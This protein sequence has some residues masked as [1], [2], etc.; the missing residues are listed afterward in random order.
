MTPD[1][2]DLASPP[3]ELLNLATRI[4]RD[5]DRRLRLAAL[6]RRISLSQL[7]DEVLDRALP[8]VEELAECMKGAATDA[9]S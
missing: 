3:G 9:R 5:V 2:K 4:S 7:I 6:V 1:S 8:P